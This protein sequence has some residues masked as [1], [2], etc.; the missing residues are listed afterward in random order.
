[1][2]TTATV[3]TKK[4]AADGD[5]DTHHDVVV[6]DGTVAN[7]AGVPAA[8]A[9]TAETGEADDV[10]DD[11][12]YWELCPRRHELQLSSW[13]AP[14]P[15]SLCL[16]VCVFNSLYCKLPLMSHVCHIKTHFIKVLC[17]F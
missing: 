6:D 7:A 9:A 1:M 15:L 13:V 3:T 14:T 8:T 4:T 11:P 12:E 16:C 2:T 17:F 5:N 10:V